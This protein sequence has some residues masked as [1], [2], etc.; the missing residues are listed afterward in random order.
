VDELLRVL[1][2]ATSG[3]VEWAPN[4]LAPLVAMK[5]AE[6]AVALPMFGWLAVM[7]TV[8]IIGTILAHRFLSQDPDF[9]MWPVSLYVVFGIAFLVCM[10]CWVGYTV[11]LR[12]FQAA[13]ELYV[14]KA[15]LGK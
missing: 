9:V 1:A 14:L 15:L 6:F 8:I 3:L 4:Q 2:K 11:E 10:G 5:Q 13:P 7:S 12:I